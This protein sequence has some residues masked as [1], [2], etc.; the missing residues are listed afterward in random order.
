MLLDDLLN[1]QPALRRLISR[2]RRH[3]QRPVDTPLHESFL[4]QAALQEELFTRI[5]GA[6]AEPAGLKKNGQYV[7]D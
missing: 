7:R 4:D 6:G 5:V 1:D 2:L 3:S